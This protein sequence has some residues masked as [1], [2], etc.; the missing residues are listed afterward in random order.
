MEQQ[1][2]QMGKRQFRIGD[3]AEALKVK[4]FVIRF[5]EKEFDLR[6]DRSQGGQRFYTK[7]DLNLFMTIKDLLYVQGF[8]ISGAKKQ[9]EALRKG[10]VLLDQKNNLPEGNFQAAELM[11]DLPED[12]VEDLV[13][14][15]GVSENHELELATK[16]QRAESID[17]ATQNS[18]Q[19]FVQSE[20]E[21]AVYAKPYQEV[22]VKEKSL[23]EQES[24]VRVAQE[25]QESIEEAQREALANKAFREQLKPLKETLL[26]LKKRLG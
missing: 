4:K 10:T 26:E 3:L 18:E 1:K 14:Q 17:Q 24:I 16:E 23:I 6:S 19:E 21:S 15:D 9:L 2:V 13:L 20:K 5:W 8:T 11:Q 7:E 12:L 22:L 25:L